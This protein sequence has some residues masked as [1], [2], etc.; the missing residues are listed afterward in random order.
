MSQESWVSTRLPSSYI[1]DSAG[2]LTTRTGDGELAVEF[3]TSDR[4]GARGTFTLTPLLFASA[5]VQ[6]NSSA[7]TVSANARLRWEHRPGCELFGRL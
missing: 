2:R 1:A 5:L 4:V 7:H 6:Y 3:Q